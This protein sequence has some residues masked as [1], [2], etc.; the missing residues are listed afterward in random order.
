MNPLRH[1]LSRR[2]FVSNAAKTFLGVSAVS[3]LA[4]PRAGAVPGQGTSALK[5]AATARNV[6]YLYMTGG[7]TNPFSLLIAVPVVVSA[8]SLPVRLTVG[9]G[10]LVVAMATLLVFFHLPLPWTLGA[11]GRYDGPIAGKCVIAAVRN[12]VERVHAAASSLAPAITS[13]LASALSKA[14][15][16]VGAP[17]FPK[18]F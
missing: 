12:I 18:T 7:M 15:T 3:H 11:V 4:V 8:T 16:S 9:L 13:D 2:A 6:I 10:F 1:D 17:F 14:P 5:Q